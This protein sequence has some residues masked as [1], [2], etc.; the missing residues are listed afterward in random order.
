MDGIFGERT[1]N[2]YILVRKGA[3]GNITWL[4]QAMLVCNSYNIE[5]DGIFGNNTE[6]VVKQFQEKSGIL[7]DGIV[8]KNTF[9]KLFE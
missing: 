8:G 3:S 2:A 1:E 5:V 9:K 7:V 6:K 4:I